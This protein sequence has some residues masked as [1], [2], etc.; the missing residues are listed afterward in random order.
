[1]VRED[2]SV[3]PIFPARGKNLKT[4]KVIE[5]MEY[6][7]DAAVVYDTDLAKEAGFDPNDPDDRLK[8]LGAI[9][10]AQRHLRNP[11]LCNPV[12]VWERVHNAGLLKRIDDKGILIVGARKRKNLGRACN[13]AVR[14][15]ANI[16]PKK[17]DKNGDLT[18]YNA[19]ATQ[20]GTLAV[21]ASS[22]ATKRLEAM[23]D[24]TKVDPRKL[25]E[26]LK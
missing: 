2:V 26:Q 23:E 17:L 12:A 8:L 16:D 1:M 25:L 6:N 19:L 24:T 21:F 5:F 11:Q 9:R 18:E 7:Y 20:L 10:A 22:G 3:K 4:I 13:R 15:V 14:Y